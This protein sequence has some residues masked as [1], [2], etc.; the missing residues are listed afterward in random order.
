MHS[1]GSFTHQRVHKVSTSEGSS[2]KRRC[3]AVRGLDIGIIANM[4]E[5]LGVPH[6]PQRDL[7]PVAVREEIFH[8]M[9]SC[10]EETVRFVEIG[11]ISTLGATAVLDAVAEDSADELGVKCELII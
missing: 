4:T 10:A 8:G 2:H 11:A 6:L 3:W 1:L 7:A 5:D 9:Q